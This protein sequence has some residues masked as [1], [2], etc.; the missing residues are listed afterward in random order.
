M[1]RDVYY[2]QIQAATSDEAA[3]QAIA[4][5]HR[6]ETGETLPL[7]DD[8]TLVYFRAALADPTGSSW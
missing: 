1:T 3:R 8:A 6:Y 4:D 7:V 5:L 2:A